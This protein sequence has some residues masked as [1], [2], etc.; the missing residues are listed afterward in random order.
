MPTTDEHFAAAARN[1]KLLDRL[2]PLVEEFPEW[3]AVVAFYK[4]MHVVEAVIYETHGERHTFGHETR[5]G[6]LKRNGRYRHL[7]KHYWPLFNASLVARYMEVGHGRDAKEYPRFADYMS[8]KIVIADLV[9]HY[10]HQ[11]E[12]GAGRLLP[13]GWPADIPRCVPPPPSPPSPPALPPA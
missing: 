5:N 2:I 1:Q 3:V 12:V 8:P 10:L 9:K 11:V 7:H 4:A 13:R 6:L